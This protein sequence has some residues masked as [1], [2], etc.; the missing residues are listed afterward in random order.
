MKTSESLEALRRANPRANAALG[1]SVA[2]TAEAVRRQVSGGAVRQTRPRRT[3]VR[4]RRVGVAAVGASLVAVAVTAAVL[5]G[6]SPGGEDA[7]AA[8]T[9]AATVTAASAERSGRAVVRITHDG[10]PWAGSTIRWHDD[11]LA[12][13]QDSPTRSGKAGSPLLL[14]D[15]MMYGIDPRD[16]VWVVLG[17]PKSI[18]AGSGT[19]PGEYLA[20]VREDVGGG[21]LHRLTTAMSGLTTSSRAGGSTVYS[22]TV[23]AALVARE[24]GFK[25][26]RPIRLLPFGYVA[27]GE[28]A[29]PSAPLEATV[30]IGADGI[31]REVSV[32]WGADG[33][34]WR[35]SVAYDG[36][37]RT[38]PLTRPANA[39]PL[40]ERRAGS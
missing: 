3:S 31:V 16:G 29:D 23:P 26:G 14:V 27:H 21:T 37:G 20:A 19:T 25:E 2:A 38:A 34:A 22:G 11:D 7:V 33:S 28:A 30:T 6:G 8:I 1:D 40:R 39:R 15:G 36:L 12:V 4:R 17:S 5:T 24:A 13:F 18:D 32:S 9:R 35:Y 10:T